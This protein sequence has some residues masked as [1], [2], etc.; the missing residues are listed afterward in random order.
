MQMIAFEDASADVACLQPK[1][2]CGERRHVKVIPR[3]GPFY[4]VLKGIEGI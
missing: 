2:R 3:N 4:G 1:R